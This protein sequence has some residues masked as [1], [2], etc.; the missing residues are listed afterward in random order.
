MKGTLEQ[1]IS[2]MGLEVDNDQ[3]KELAFKLAQA[4]LQGL[5]KAKDTISGKEPLNL[6]SNY[7]PTKQEDA[8][9]E[10]GPPLTTLETLINQHRDHQLST[11]TWRPAPSELLN[12]GTNHCLSVI[13]VTYNKMRK[14]KHAPSSIVKVNDI[15]V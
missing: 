1:V 9:S 7:Q 8:K 6:D 10:N 11:G 3:R 13:Q 5:Q 14:A 4:H 12:R 15:K 2:N